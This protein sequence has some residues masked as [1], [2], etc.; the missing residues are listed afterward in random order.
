MRIHEVWERLVGRRKSREIVRDANLLHDPMRPA[1]HCPRVNIA[2]APADASEDDF[3]VRPRSSAILDSGWSGFVLLPTSAMEG[4]DPRI[5]V[6]IHPPPR[7]I[8]VG[9]TEI[10][11]NQSYCSLKIRIMG[12]TG[13]PAEIVPELISFMDIPYGLIGL[14]LLVD[15][16]GRL[17]IDGERRRFTLRL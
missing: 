7:L 13:Q 2:A 11:L 6:P 16:G 1:D 8:T 14:G 9:G 12:N 3:A 5:L 15:E 17:L 10:Q 4:L